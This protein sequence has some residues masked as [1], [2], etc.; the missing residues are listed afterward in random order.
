MAATAPFHGRT[1]VV[2]HAHP[3]DEA[4][5]TAATM[6][7]LA[8]FGARVILVTAT[9]GE[10]GEALVPLRSGE[11]VA[12]RRRSELERAAERLGVARLVLLGQRDS[13]LPGTSDNT[14]P[15]ALAC[16]DWSRVARVL[17]DI[18]QDEDAEA[19]IH[20]DS[21]GI[22]GHP[23]HI[24]VHEIGRHAAH[25]LGVTAYESTVDRERIASPGA[26]T[27]LLHAAAAAV[28]LPYG[29]DPGS[30]ALTLVASRVELEVKRQAIDTHR[31]QIAPLSVEHA[32]FS[33]TYAHE[34]YL[35][36]GARGILDELAEQSAAGVPEVDVHD[37]ATLAVTSAGQ[38]SD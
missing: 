27:H 31:S 12:N 38:L 10:L 33:R 26:Q 2:F 30:L 11:T 29:V 22:Y 14:A 23:D 16:A 32:E 34:W 24:A 35:R 7:R 13:G 5:F 4:I 28:G 3:D 21:H 9:L 25:A 20:Y 36:D 18:G 8:D 37:G 6:R 15:G 17:A 19:I 1:V